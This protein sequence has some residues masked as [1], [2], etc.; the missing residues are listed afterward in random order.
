MSSCHLFYIFG[1]WFFVLVFVVCCCKC[2]EI[3]YITRQQA[4]ATRVFVLFFSFVLLRLLMFVVF[5][6]FSSFTCRPRLRR[7]QTIFRICLFCFGSQ[8]R[9][10]RLR[11]GKGKRR[12][13]G[14]E[15]ES[16]SIRCVLWCDSDVGREGRNK[17]SITERESIRNRFSFKWQYIYTIHIHTNRIYNYCNHASNAG[18]QTT[19]N[20]KYNCWCF[21]IRLKHNIIHEYV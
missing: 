17:K 4:R 11:A 14:R 2:L 19:T 7:L 9:T 21:R 12:C 15:T 8:R 5:L 10:T 3:R 18:T 13:R 6:W 1:H 16:E 20:A